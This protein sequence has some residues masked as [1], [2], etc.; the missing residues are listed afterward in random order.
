MQQSMLQ[1]IAI[2]CLK[3]NKQLH[4]KGDYEHVSIITLHQLE[5]YRAPICAG[6]IQLTLRGN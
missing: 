1:R 3:S 6:V 2:C 5:K 4:Y